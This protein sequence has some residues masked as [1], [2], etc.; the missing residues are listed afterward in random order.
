MSFRHSMEEGRG[1][2]LI[3]AASA[4]YW[5]V[6]KAFIFSSN[7]V[8]SSLAK[9]FAT[10]SSSGTCPQMPAVPNIWGETTPTRKL[11]FSSTGATLHAS[12]IFF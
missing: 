12:F 2:G 3:W 5:G 10:A 8:R 7:D 6:T 11:C 9:A 1:R 4:R